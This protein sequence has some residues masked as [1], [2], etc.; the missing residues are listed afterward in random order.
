MVTLHHIPTQVLTKLIENS[1]F[2]ISSYLEY[3][4]HFGEL[5]IYFLI[6]LPYL[7]INYG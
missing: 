2:N 6:K 1:P 4:R 7:S 5:L 3:E